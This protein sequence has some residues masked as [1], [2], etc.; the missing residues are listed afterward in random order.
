MPF[1]A[2]HID[3]PAQPDVVAERVRAAVADVPTFWQSIKSSWKGPRPSGRPFL[4]NVEGRSFR[5]RRDINYRNS[6]LPLIRGRIVPTPSGSRVNV[7]MFMHPFTFMFMIFWFGF[8]V[9]SLS[10][11]LDAN[12]A[13]TY[14]PLA[15]IVFGLV[16][17]LGG[18]FFEALK[19]M[20]L[21]SEAVFNPA[22]SAAPGRDPQSVLGEKT[23]VP[24]AERSPRAAILL[25]GVAL[26]L[27][28]AMA[29]MNYYQ[30][31]LRSSPVFAAAVNLVSQSTSAK[32]ALGEPLKPGR[33][34][35][36]MVH[37]DRLSG[38]AA[39]AVPV[40]GSLTKGTLYVIANRMPAGWNI[41]RAVLQT[42]GSGSSQRPSERI[43]LSPATQRE[44]FD[45]PSPG[46][47][48]LLPL[49]DAA[50]ADVKDLPAYYQARL[51]LDVTLLPPQQ[52]APDTLDIVDAKH[53]QLLG[54]K[55]LAAIQQN[56][57]E[58][59]ADLDSVIL[60]VTSQDLNIQTSGWDYA[61]NYRSG[62]FGVFSTARLHGLP[63]YAGK[64]PEVYALRVRK[65]AT[66]NIAVLHYPLTLSPD[67]TSAL[68]TSTFTT[69]DIDEM[70]ESFAG[71]SGVTYSVGEY[72]C[73]SITQGPGAKQSIRLE[74]PSDPPA[75][76]RF[77]RFITYQGIPSFIMS[78]T[79]FTFAGHPSFPFVRKYRVQ[80]DVSRAFGIGAS[81]T[82]DIFPSGENRTFASM[83]LIEADGSPVEYTR[84]SR[85]TS[86][87]DARLRAGQYMSN[88]FSLSTIEWQ[89]RGWDL[90]TV[91]GWIYHFPASWPGRTWQQGALT[92]I[93]SAT[94]EGF[95]VQRDSKSNL[96]VLRTTDGES[97]E[98]TCDAKDR[99][100]AAKASSGRQVFYE[101]DEGG[102]LTH[103]R[104][105]QD[106]EEFYDYDA[107]NRLTSVLDAQ[108]KPLLV[109]TY[110]LI[111]EVLTQTLADGRKLT[112][113]SKFKES[114]LLDYFK[115]TLPDGY[116]IE[117]ELTRD[118][119]TR[120]W[121]QA[122]PALDATLPH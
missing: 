69:A 48:Y 19:V 45:Y 5:I 77:E 85:G 84:V 49:D 61:T 95:A 29:G 58:I 25:V 111:G 80:D 1:Y 113:D 33:A 74:C 62:R 65:M 59:A 64:N 68:A 105:N 13:R 96:H 78:H 18:F 75:D 44:S 107:M 118:G 89:G 8:L 6:F 57:P 41:E 42:S 51:R 22:I 43:D 104:D 67:A 82:F 38:Y 81:D 63:W 93:R 2:F 121:P 16:L 11:V 79:D 50:A 55:V 30:Y 110:G 60:A 88:P 83:Q 122:P 114:R 90:T 54:E 15:M 47:V 73:V 12:V 32:S 102:R 115:L 98:F 72:P 92:G 39:L 24:G 37:E 86:W 71:A 14:I 46:R 56:H 117:W 27:V 109:N 21:L 97:I 36:G 26:V 119:L 53:K 94:G 106:G 23:A 9:A 120:S 35:Q 99:V 40:S 70:G 91:D 66:K 4:G 31:R 10:K 20:P 28:L 7:F 76:S 112:Y 52:L 101:Y 17:S 100:V 87:T 108:H 116:T 103:M 3:V 34:V